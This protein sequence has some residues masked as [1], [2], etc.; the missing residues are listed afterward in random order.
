VIIRGA[1]GS[2]IEPAAA[3]LMA[4]FFSDPVLVWLV[5]EERSRRRFLRG[6]FHA[7]LE[8]SNESGEL[9][10]AEDAS[11]VCGVAVWYPP[12]RVRHPTGPAMDNALAALDKTD[13]DRLGVLGDATTE[14][15]PLE[16]HFYLWL[17]AV[18]TEKRGAGIGGAL[19]TAVLDI[20]D[21]RR[22]VAFLEATRPEN[23]RLY[24]RYGFEATGEIR[25]PDGPTKWPMIRTP[26]A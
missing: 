22:T 16:H 9:R 11:E 26:H 20:C 14:Y 15:A 13:M 4:G 5:P 19:L 2:D 25:L 24:K 12:G 6:L 17:M 23:R 10:V 3:V 21:E 8:D 7:V 1:L 18:S